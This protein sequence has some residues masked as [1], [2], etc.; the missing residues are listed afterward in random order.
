MTTTTLTSK[1][2]ATKA[3]EI[4]RHWRVVDA[5]GATLGRLSTRVR[6]AIVAHAGRLDDMARDGRMHE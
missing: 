5:D 6:D 3:S 2:H 1:T 4:S